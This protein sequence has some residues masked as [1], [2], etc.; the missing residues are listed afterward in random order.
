GTGRGGDRR[1]TAVA[2][3]TGGLHSELY[4]RGMRS[5][6]F[7]SVS[8]L[9]CGGTTDD[10]I[11]NPLDASMDTITTTDSPTSDA[12]VETSTSDTMSTVDSASVDSK[13]VDSTPSDGNVDAGSC[14]PTWCGCGT[15]MADQ[16]VCSHTDHGCPLGC[17]S[18]P[19]PALSDPT[20]CSTV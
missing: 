18:G 1:A 17:A 12:V 15:C 11:G 13:V 6:V 9:A 7:L 4:N 8:L 20:T 5:L 19:C 3:L 2:R 10:G 16:I 14:K